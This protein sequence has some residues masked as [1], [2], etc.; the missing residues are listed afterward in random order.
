MEWQLILSISHLAV[1]HAYGDKPVL[2]MSIFVLNTLL[3]VR[4]TST[5]QQT[6]GSNPPESCHAYW[7][8]VQ[9]VYNGQRHFR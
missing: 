4:F 7:L 5:G 2:A 8:R 1:Y 9:S 3:I 6:P